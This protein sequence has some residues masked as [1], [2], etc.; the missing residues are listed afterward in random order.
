MSSLR[1]DGR[2]GLITGGSRG[3][4]RATAEALA[5]HGAAVVLTAREAAVAEARAAEIAA[6]TGA[7]VFGVA[8]DVADPAQV[9]VLVRQVFGR[10]K[11]LDILVNNAGVMPE[12]L[13]GMNSEEAIRQVLD[14]NVAGAFRMLQAAAR[15]IERSGGGSIVNVSSI[16]GLRGGVGLSLYAAS[17]AA[18][19]G[20]TLSAAKELASKKIRVNAVAPGFIETDMTSHFSDAKR[21]ETLGN[22]ALGRI[23]TPREVADVILF[24]NSDL[25][26]YVTGQVLGIDG[27][28]VA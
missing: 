18:M 3:I 13:L 8:A 5:E 2:V 25:A 14:V 11:R 19:V 26:R 22:I 9:S 21:Q 24:L 20:L 6:N 16:I 17:K 12:A 1:L 27:G 10:L 4:G 23:G 7:A 28:M 15:L